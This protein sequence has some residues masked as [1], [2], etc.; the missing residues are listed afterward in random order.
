MPG[1]VGE[2]R[3]G[4]RSWNNGEG[5]GA[6]MGSQA[7]VARSGG[8]IVSDQWGCVGIGAG[9]G[10]AM[11]R[12]CSNGEATSDDGEDEDDGGVSNGSCWGSFL[13]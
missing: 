13:I 12:L 9:S 2:G 10:G 4:V 7:G 8:G 5:G 6:A 11:E 3:G 1:W